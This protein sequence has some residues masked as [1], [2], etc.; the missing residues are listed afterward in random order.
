RNLDITGEATSV[1]ERNLHK[2][3]ASLPE[4]PDVRTVFHELID[5]RKGL[6]KAFRLMHE[7]GLLTKLIPEFGNIGWHYQYNYYHA[8]T[9]DEHSIRVVEFL[10]K[11]ALGKLSKVPELSEIMADV[12]AKGALYLAGLLHDIGK[13]KGRGHS[14]RGERMAARAL[15]RL[16]FD[17]RTVDLVKFLIREHLA[18]THTSQRRD[19]E[20]EDTIND[21]LKRAGSTGRLRMLTLLTFADLLALSEN[22]LTDWKKALLLRLYNKTM[23]LLDR[24][25]EELSGKSVQHVISSVRRSNLETLPKHT[26]R[27]HLEQLPDQYIRVTSPSHIRAHIRGITRMQNRGVWA[28]FRHNGDVTLL[29]VITRDYPKALSDICGSITSSDINIIGAQI[30]TRNDG[31]IID[32][33]LVVDDKGC[34]MIVPENQK[35][36]KKNL[37]SVVNGEASVTELIRHHVHRW[38]RRKRKV[39][40]SKPRVRIHNDISSRYT[41]IDVFAT[42]YTGLLYDV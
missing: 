16:G 19:M 30:F 29:T 28:S 39:I 6:G 13:G 38:K 21:F 31:I 1:I 9:T 12:P 33:F 2:L 40:F 4:N 3:D 24:G 23:M 7:H 20:D 42:D 11:I 34:S 8:Y 10:E 26:I 41:V 37:S 25:Y 5:M 17:E 32:T 35:T 14:L 18:M 22:A 36:F 27:E 15:E